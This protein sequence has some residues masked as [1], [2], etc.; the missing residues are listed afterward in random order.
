MRSRE[1]RL[2]SMSNFGKIGQSVTKILR[3][4]NFW[5]WQTPPSWIF[6]FVK[7]HWQTVSGRH[8]LI[9]LLN[10]VKIGLRVVE[11]LQFLEF[12]KW[13]SPPSCS[14]WNR[15]ILF[16]VWAESIETHQH[17]KFRQNRSICCE[18]IKIFRF[19]KMAAAAI[20]NCRIHKISLADSGRM[21]QTHHFIKFHQN[22]SFHCGDVA[23]CR[24]FKMA[25]AAI[26][27]FWNLKILLAIRVARVE[28]HQHAKFCQNRSVSCKDIMIFRFFKMAAAAILDCRVHKILL[29]VGVRRAYMHHCTKFRQNRSFL[30]G[31]I[32][33]YRILKMA[34]VRHL[35]FVGGIF[36]PPSVSIW[37]VSIALQNLVYYR[38]SSFY[39]MNIL[40]FGPFG[41]K[42]PIHAPKIGVFGQ[43]D[44]LN[45]LQYQKG[46]KRHI[47]AWVC[48][49][50]A[51]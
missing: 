17:A 41:W 33:I 25:T 19:F 26:L 20:L 10:V 5:K 47:L 1:S 8:R 39:N 50:W 9:I 45:G 44:P 42:M 30:C 35:G 12:S 29:A 34:A 21:A 40:I 38:C 27:D 23:I 28:T 4:F 13:P 43:F 11:I 31:Y 15:E 18:D 2:M 32:A 46:Q 22:R 48:I 24:I 14:F 51:I 36:G 7:F 6:K 37:G 16:A 3:F 49:I